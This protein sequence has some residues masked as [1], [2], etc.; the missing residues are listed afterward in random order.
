MGMGGRLG[1]KEELEAIR[2]GKV[3]GK[4]L[5][6]SQRAMTGDQFAAW[7]HLVVCAIRFVRCA[8]EFPDIP[9]ASAEYYEALLDAQ[10]R[11]ARAWDGEPAWVPWPTSEGFWWMVSPHT[12]KPVPVEARASGDD[13]AIDTT[14][15]EDTTY[16]HEAGD[17]WLFALMGPPPS[18][19]AP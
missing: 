4:T 2:A 8:T 14:G 16:R 11:E 17:G 7:K 15:S 12:S 13:F 9:D 3:P 5:V 10:A 19:P 6:S 18:P 1:S